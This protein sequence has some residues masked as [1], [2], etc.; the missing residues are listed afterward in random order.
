M[1]IGQELVQAARLFKVLGSESRLLL[2]RLV[3]QEP[4]S[5]GAL[6][7]Q[8]GMS[9]PLVSQHL[10]TLRGAGLVEARRHGK[11]VIYEIADLHVSHVVPDALEHVREPVSATD[12]EG[13]P[14]SSPPRKDES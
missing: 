11:E 8:S 6:V 10:R 2:L 7:E 14:L 3:A 4:C 1:E 9:Q 5:V 12:D 13:N